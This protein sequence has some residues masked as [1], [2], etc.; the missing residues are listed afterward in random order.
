MALFQLVYVSSMVAGGPEVLADILGSSIRKNK[1]NGI[2]GMMLFAEGNIM[3]ALEGEKET[4]LRTWRAIQYD[5]RHKD[6]LVLIQQETQSRQF[7][8]WSMG[9][10]H[11][12]KSDF[13]KFPLGAHFFESRSD[14]V[15]LRVRAGEALTVLKNFAGWMAYAYVLDNCHP[16]GQSRLRVAPQI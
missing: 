3:Q 14:E 8:S 15:S 16:G 7:A 12:R 10:R 1:L 6:L 5:E 9:F 4:V 13:E 2:T 11:L